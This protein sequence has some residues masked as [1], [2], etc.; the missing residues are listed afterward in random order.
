MSNMN[1]RNYGYFETLMPSITL[2]NTASG[3]SQTPQTVSGVNVAP[4]ALKDPWNCVQFVLDVT[5]AATSSGDTLDVTIQTLLG[6]F[7][8]DVVHMT[9]VLGNG[10]PIRILAKLANANALAMFSNATA[11]TAG[12]MRDLIG[13]QWAV[14]WS[15]GGSGSFT[16]SVTA[17]PG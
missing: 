1:E 14:K 12:N 7:W 6:S 9:Q 13:D 16:F 3:N 10:G 17:I 5:A 8:V 11:L 15:L 2:T 4:V